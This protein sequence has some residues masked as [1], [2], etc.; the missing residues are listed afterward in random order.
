MKSPWVSDTSS[1]T[2][3]SCTIADRWM[4]ANWCAIQPALQRRE[5]AAQQVLIPPDVKR[6]VVV[7]RFNPVD[8]GPID[9][10][11][12]LAAADG[13]ATGRPGPGPQLLQQ[14]GQPIAALPPAQAV[15]RASQRQLE[16][17]ACERLQQVVDRME[18]ERPKRVSIEGRDENHCRQLVRR[19]RS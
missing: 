3:S 16:P 19:Q 12:A 2:R 14:R 7:G 6:H 1:A 5:R 18:I 11:D 9:H 10:D 15:L 17:L 4:R 8:V 13:D